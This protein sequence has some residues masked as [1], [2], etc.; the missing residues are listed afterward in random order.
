MKRKVFPSPFK[1]SASLTTSCRLYACA[2]PL[3]PIV[4]HAHLLSLLNIWKAYYDLI[5]YAIRCW[6]LMTTTAINSWLG[7]LQYVYYC[8]SEKLCARWP[9]SEKQWYN[10]YR[11]QAHRSRLI[12][13]SIRCSIHHLLCAC[14]RWA[15]C[16]TL[17]VC[18]CQMDHTWRLS[19]AI[20]ISSSSFP[21]LTPMICT[22]GDF[23][24]FTHPF[25]KRS[26][27]RK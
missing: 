24:H 23:Q 26:A 3:I 6:V 16:D 4:C 25:T 13:S 2:D 9:A 14:V 12:S 10:T 18:M 22:L 20:L 21:L 1:S 8:C 7:S 15:T 11:S 19:L 27:M 17:I 5:F